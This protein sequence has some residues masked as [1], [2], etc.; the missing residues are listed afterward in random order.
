MRIKWEFAV[1]FEA[2]QRERKKEDWN[3]SYERSEGEICAFHHLVRCGY[4]TF[5]FGVHCL[6]SSSKTHTL[7]VLNPENSTWTKPHQFMHTPTRSTKPNWI[8]K[9]PV[10]VL[11]FR[12]FITDRA[13]IW[14]ELFG[15]ASHF[16]RVTDLLLNSVRCR[17]CSQWNS[18]NDRTAIFS[19]KS[20][21]K[22][23]DKNWKWNFYNFLSRKKIKKLCD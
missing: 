13:V 12:Q 22:Y 9:Y 16:I 23:Q 8:H 2:P 3:P 11:S 14:M 19:V 18:V 10:A 17:C 5:Q 1:Y 20:S 7:C 21:E 4:Y 15:I 6:A